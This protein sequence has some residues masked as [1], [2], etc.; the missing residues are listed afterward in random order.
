MRIRKLFV[1]AAGTA[2][3]AAV[4]CALPSSAFASG[5]VATYNGHSYE[6]LQAAVDATRSVIDAEIELVANT[7]ENITVY[8]NNKVT[9]NLSHYTLKA[10]DSSAPTITNNG[11]LTISASGGGKIVRTAPENSSEAYNNTKGY[12]VVYNPN[13]AT[14]L[15]IKSGTIQ[16]D[17]KS[18][19]TGPAICTYSTLRI[20]NG[21]FESTSGSYGSLYVYSGTSTIS[22]GYF[23]NNECPRVLYALSGTVNISGGTF[24]GS[25]YTT[26]VAA[27]SVANLRCEAIIS[28]GLFKGDVRVG[29]Y[30]SFW[31]GIYK[32]EIAGGTIEG[33]LESYLRYGKNTQTGEY[34]LPSS[35]FETTVS[36]NA[37]VKGKIKTTL[38]TQGYSGDTTVV[39][40][41]TLNGGSFADVSALDFLGTGKTAAK[42]KDGLYKVV[43]E[44]RADAAIYEL[45]GS[46]KVQISKE[47]ARYVYF[48]DKAEAEKYADSLSPKGTV[49][50]LRLKVTFQSFGETLGDY[51]KYYAVDSS[52]AIG[53]LPTLKSIPG[54]TFDGWYVDDE[55]I[56]ASYV[57]ANEDVVVTASWSWNDTYKYAKAVNVEIP[58]LVA[59]DMLPTTAKAYLTCE[60]GKTKIETSAAL[61]W[62]KADGTVVE[63]CSDA[64]AD[65]TY[66]VTALIA[67][68]S[69]VGV[70]YRSDT[71]VTFNDL[72]AESK[73][74][75]TNGNVKATY[76]VTTPA[77]SI[78]GAQVAVDG[79]SFAYT[80][81]RIKPAVTVTLDGIELEKD[82]DYTVKYAANK[83]VG[84]A[85]VTVAGTG[86]YAGT[87][88]AQFDI[89]P[90]NITNLKATA[91]KKSVKLAWDKRKAQTDGFVICWATSKV[92][93]AKGKALKTATVKKAAA[94]SYTAS[95]LKSGKRYY[96]KVRAYKVVDGV[97][98]YSAWSAV[99][100]AKAK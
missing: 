67:P 82:T 27:N 7:S 78:N 88:T 24:E 89:V 10:A 72:A 46:Y 28:G 36:G 92:K 29:N 33:S 80:G 13:G 41:M 58:A 79:S 76:S 44:P 47:P 75:V 37:V 90:A 5:Y 1:A 77:I 68:A 96:F 25:G 83:K 9:L 31:S 23:K 48:D 17:G 49:T 94:K 12:G 38:E 32:A 59:G 57:P 85:T 39:P 35:S 97:K 84:T 20:E 65:E 91:A 63:D 99:K 6:T 60:D 56:D 14:G 40:T 16:F 45:P 100:G 34:T 11:T 73:A 95:K 3:A 86:I 26:E 64:L 50:H 21:R 19:Y 4:V 55:K 8:S 43:D 98:V 62:S 30:P 53:T 93:L 42:A 70:V 66:T 2:F 54:Y 74:F 51:T 87:V 52:A 22:G 71:A 61:T 69:Y 15:T 81:S 18:Y